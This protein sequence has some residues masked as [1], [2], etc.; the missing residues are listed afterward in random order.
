MTLLGKIGPMSRISIFKASGKSLPVL[1]LALVLTLVLLLTAC[2]AQPVEPQSTSPALTET[3]PTAEPT[4]TTEWFPRTPTPTL[5]AVVSTPTP[6]PQNLPPT[7]EGPLIFS[8]DFTDQ[9]LWQTLRDKNGS[10]AYGTRS[11][12]LAVSAE[13]GTVA[14]WSTHKL[15]ANFYLEVTA[16]L[17]LCSTGDRYGITFWRDSDPGTFRLWV[18]C[19]GELKLEKLVGDRI[20]TL[21]EWI[22]ARHLQPGAPAQNKL[23]IEANNGILAIFVNDMLQFTYTTQKNLSGE[24]G[25]IA[26]SA[27]KNA[28][29]VIFSDLIVSQP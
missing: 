20:D 4:A 23:A 19:E 26:R 10:V 2:Q 8:D 18:S 24:L 12:S 13:K 27:G 7:A 29:T 17:S 3:L 16:D 1:I 25:L 11:L 6:N 9:T 28:E 15:P 5:L 22:T 21:Q 14:T